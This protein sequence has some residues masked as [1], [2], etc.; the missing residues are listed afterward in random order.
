MNMVVETIRLADLAPNPLRDF[1]ADPINKENQ[2]HLAA[3]IKEHGFWNNAIIGYNDD[4]G[5]FI[6]CGHTRV[7]ASIDNGIKTADLNVIVDPTDEQIARIYAIENA[8]QRGNSSTALLG[9]IAAAVKVIARRAYGESP[10]NI[11]LYGSDFKEVSLANLTQG[12][13]GLQIEAF[14]KNIPGINTGV[15]KNQLAILKS[16]GGYEKILKEVQKEVTEENRKAAER[17]KKEAAAAAKTGNT[18]AANAAEKKAEVLAKKTAVLGDVIQ[19]DK[20]KRGGQALA[21]LRIGTLFT[22]PHIA[23]TFYDRAAKAV[24]EGMMETSQQYGFAKHLIACAQDEGRECNSRYIAENFSSELSAIRR[25]KNRNAKTEKSA[26]EAHM[27]WNDKAKVIMDYAA[28]GARQF[29]NNCEKLAEHEKKRPKDCSLLASPGFRKSIQDLR[30]W[31][32]VLEKRGI[33]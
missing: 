31:L 17:L 16:T 23:Q 30:K 25:E 5:Y 15:I 8:T 33:A 20:D 9:S 21:D 11:G 6:I 24:K 29:V 22:T 2:K 28:S 27:A 4:Q 13:G 7:G 10:T 12:V 1:T 26:L 18:R 14:L 3:S 19:K 32:L